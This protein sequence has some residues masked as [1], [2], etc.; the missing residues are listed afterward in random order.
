[1]RLNEFKYLKTEIR[2]NVVSLK[3]II[4]HIDEVKDLVN[5]RIK[6]LGKKP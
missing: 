2:N 4:S 3:Q 1:M 6:E 5:L